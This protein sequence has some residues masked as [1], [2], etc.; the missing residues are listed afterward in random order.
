MQINEAFM[1]LRDWS[2]R[3]GAA[4]LNQ[5]PGCWERKIDEDWSVSINGHREPRNN[6]AGLEVPPFSAFIQWKDWPAGVIDPGGGIIVAGEFANENIFIDAL[7]AAGAKLPDEAACPAS[8]SIFRCPRR[9]R[10]VSRMRGDR[11][12]PRRSGTGHGS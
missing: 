8:P 3:Q 12:G 6:S 2:K 1:L 10:R 4:P 5:G 9:C 11:D 7:K